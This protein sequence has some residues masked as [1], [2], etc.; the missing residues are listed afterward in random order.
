MCPSGFA[1]GVLEA[2]EKFKAPMQTALRL[3]HCR[4]LQ[5]AKNVERSSGTGEVTSPSLFV[6]HFF[7]PAVCC[8]YGCVPASM[9]TVL[10]IYLLCQFKI[11]QLKMWCIYTDYCVERNMHMQYIRRM[12]VMCC[13]QCSHHMS[14]KIKMKRVYEQIP[15]SIWQ[16]EY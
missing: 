13:V 8:G 7:V 6:Q 12:Y 1:S 4:M 15:Y 11:F 9:N 5:S 3:S 14:Y 2:D 10:R 16:C